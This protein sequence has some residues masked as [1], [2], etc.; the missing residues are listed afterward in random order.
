MALTV[1]CAVFLLTMLAGMPIAFAMI[2]ASAVYALMTALDLGLLTLQLYSGLDSFLLIAIPLFILTSEVMDRSG[3]ADRIYNFAHK[4]VG[5]LPG[6]I[7]HVDV[8]NSV[9]FSGMS[10]SALADVGGIGRLGYLAMV[11]NGYKPPFSAAVVVFSSVIGPLTP[12]SIPMIVLAMVSGISVQ[13]LFFGGAVPGLLVA[14]AMFAYIHFLFRKSQG[15]GHG[16]PWSAPMLA[17]AFAQGF[18]PLLTPIVLLGGIWFGVV[19]ITEAAG[20][21]VSYALLLGLVVYRTLGPVELW[22]SLKGV[23]FAC[24][25]ILILLPAAKVFGFVLTME[26]IPVLF[27]S[28]VLELTDNRWLILIAINLLLIVVGLVSDPTVNIMLF[29]PIV[30]PLAQAIGMDPVHFGVM[31]VF[32]CMIGLVTPPV[33]AALFAMIGLD[34]QRLSLESVVR[35]MLPFYLMFFVLLV[36][37]TVIPEVATALPDWLFGPG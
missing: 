28:T 22:A 12:P 3:V 32:N 2:T 10:G 29:V 36:L 15:V 37:V 25:P 8:V 1:F 24:G 21:A 17:R 31:V 18:L 26:Q 9:I 35:A 13:R 14:V 23:F 20:L 34:R 11:N 7:A 5:P 27:T 30:Y 16:E 4:L 6:G 19:T 33:G